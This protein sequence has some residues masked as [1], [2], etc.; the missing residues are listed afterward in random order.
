LVRVRAAAA[1]SSAPARA[2]KNAPAGPH[3][4]RCSGMTAAWIAAAPSSPAVSSRRRSWARLVAGRVRV[5]ARLS[6]S[7]FKG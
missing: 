4:A 3:W 7:A 5:V 2:M 1:A 6:A